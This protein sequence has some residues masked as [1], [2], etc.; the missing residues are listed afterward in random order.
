M[1]ALLMSA[2][3]SCTTTRDS[4]SD[5]ASDVAAS[6]DADATSD[7]G[8]PRSFSCGNG[9]CM[10]GESYCKYVTGGAGGSGGNGGPAPTTYTC[11]PFGD[12]AAHDCSCVHACSCSGT[13]AE[14]VLDTCLNA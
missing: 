1:F 5:A 9:T 12:C 11:V 7:T 2:A 8:A 13:S 4:G 10:T 14:G 3:P 6:A